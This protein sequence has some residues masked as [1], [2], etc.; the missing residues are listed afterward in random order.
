MAW[1]AQYPDHIAAT[2]VEFLHHIEAFKTTHPNSGSDFIYIMYLSL[3]QGGC[4]MVVRASTRGLAINAC[5]Q[6]SS[7]VINTRRNL[8]RLSKTSLPQP[9]VM[10]KA[11]RARF[12]STPGTTDGT[13]S[14]RNLKVPPPSPHTSTGGSSRIALTVFGGILLFAGGYLGARLLHGGGRYSKQRE[15]EGHDVSG[16]V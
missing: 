12:G 6:P 10:A 13:Q 15:E 14:A 7:L 11:S 8:L 1:T 5:R 3:C 2:E 16:K 9:Q 4:T